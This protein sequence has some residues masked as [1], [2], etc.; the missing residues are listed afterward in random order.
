MP[1]DQQMYAL[2]HRH[3][4]ALNER[5]H[6]LAS[7]YDRIGSQPRWQSEQSLQINVER[8]PYSKKELSREP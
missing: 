7:Y 2:C 1:N 8:A 6:V 3:Y 5:N 4:E